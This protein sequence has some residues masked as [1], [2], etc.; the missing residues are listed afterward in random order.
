M[1]NEITIGEQVIAW[2]TA[3]KMSRNTFAEYARL[4]PGA[5]W[6]IENKNSFKPGELEKI[7]K[8]LMQAASD[9][10]VPP[11]RATTK[12]K[13]TANHTD[14]QITIVDPPADISGLPTIG[15][16]TAYAIEF[17]QFIATETK[18][19][20]LPELPGFLE[21]SPTAM[22]QRDGFRRVSNSEVQTFKRCRRKWWLTYHRALRAINESPTGPRAIGDRLHRALRFHYLADPAQR[23]QVQ[24]ALESLIA[25]DWR[26]VVARY[27]NSD[28]FTGGVPLSV[29]TQFKK[30]A[31]L[32]RIIIEG[33]LEWL[34]E[35]GSDSEYEI[36]GSEV[37]LEADLPGVANTKII[38]RLDA[39]VRR[40]TDNVRLFIDHKSVGS[41]EQL[42][43][44]LHMNE[45][46][47]WYIL[48]EMLQENETAPIAGAL[49]NMMRR[50]K[51]GPTA[52]PPFYERVEVY[53]NKH[54]INS[55]MIR[56]MGV[57]ED[58]N[59]AEA[60]L[61]SGSDHRLVVYPTPTRDCVWECPFFQVCGMMDDGSHVDAMLKA[62]FTEGDPMSYYVKGNKSG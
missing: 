12:P 49:Y 62:Y 31:N 11:P 3:R 48:I 6:R 41:F 4:S 45:Q 9:V 28:E 22:S 29:E 34:A 17:P 26:A 39:R 37:Y 47:M 15:P 16:V 46:M 54:D 25:S 20:E 8:I 57:I 27:E 24:D 35:S 19:A 56:L 21:E 32:E 18:I 33:Y 13:I 14:R 44:I 43:R 7:Q 59:R 2:R 36:T 10:P 58:M 38:A 5:V 40:I 55:F 30:D 61:G 1:T 23:V 60:A 53:H 42:T 52:K 50:V 51:R